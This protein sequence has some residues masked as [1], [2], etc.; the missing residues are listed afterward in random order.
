MLLHAVQID[1][2]YSKTEIN[3]KLKKIKVNELK[4]ILSHLSIKAA[5]SKTVM[6]N[7]LLSNKFVTEDIKY[8]SKSLTLKR[9][10]LDYKTLNNFYLQ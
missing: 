7:T 10:I 6:I 9:N 2:L 8:L 5:G 1:K 3:A 4:E